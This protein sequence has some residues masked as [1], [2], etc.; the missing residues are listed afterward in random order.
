MSK[1][2]MEKACYI[3]SMGIFTSLAILIYAGDKGDKKSIH[4]LEE[5][6]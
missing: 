6:L 3:R 5:I 4:L 1:A 2:L